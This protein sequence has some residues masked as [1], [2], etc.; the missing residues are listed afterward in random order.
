MEK[1]Q[2]IV[3]CL[4]KV[5]FLGHFG[6]RDSG[7]KPF[8]RD[9]ITGGLGGGDEDFVT[10]VVFEGGANVETIKSMESKGASLGW[11]FVYYNTS[12]RN[13]KWGAIEIKIAEETCMG[14]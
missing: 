13:S 1:R 2:E 6:E 7:W 8:N 3:S 11:S 12:A 9:A 5:V 14:G 4:T 10:A